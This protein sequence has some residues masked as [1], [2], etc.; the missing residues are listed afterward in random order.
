M[1]DGIIPYFARDI[2]F[3]L[4]QQDTLS[5][6]HAVFSKSPPRQGYYVEIPGMFHI[7]FTDAPAWT[8]LAQSLGL[9]GPLDGRRGHDIV[10]AYTTAFFTGHLTDG[11]AGLLRQPPPWPEARVETRPS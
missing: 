9:S 2:G 1:P 8:P 11:P 7:N 5:T 3:A 10:R 6:Q 4:D